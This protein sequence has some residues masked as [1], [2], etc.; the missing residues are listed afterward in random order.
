MK[1]PVWTKSE[2]VI[3]IGIPSFLLK[4]GGL[5]PP[6]FQLR[7]VSR[8]AL[9]FSCLTFYHRAAFS[10][11]LYLKFP[12]LCPQADKYTLA[13]FQCPFCGSCSSF[14]AAE[15]ILRC[16]LIL[17]ASS[18]RCSS[19]NSLLV[20]FDLTVINLFGNRYAFEITRPSIFSCR[21]ISN[22]SGFCSTSLSCFRIHAGFAVYS[23]A[24]SSSALKLMITS[25]SYRD[26]E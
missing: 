24:V 25:C 13:G 7:R 1:I 8:P 9:W 18:A 3:V 14:L 17:C 5:A 21:Y 6:N 23:V 20:S 19:V 16:S 12:F 10:S 4:S 22:C 2:Y 11:I 15:L 26:S